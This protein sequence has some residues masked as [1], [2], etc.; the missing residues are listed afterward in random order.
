MRW[1]SVYPAWRF[2]AVILLLWIAARP[3]AAQA[4]AA[5]GCGDPTLTAMGQEKPFRNRV[6]LSLEELLGEHIS[7]TPAETD[8]TSRTTL[9][10]S[11]SP[12]TF[13]TLATAVPL[14]GIRSDAPYR[15]TRYIVGLGDAEFMVRGLVF[16]DRRF[17]P[18]HIIGLL[19]GI[20]APTGPRVNDS[21]GYPADDDLQPGS[22]SWDPE[23]G[24]NYSYFGSLASLFLSVSYRYTTT[25]YRGYRRGS[26]LGG[27]LALQV[28]L[29][30]RTA[31][32]LG[33][34][35]S[36][37]AASELAAQVPAPDTGGFLLSASPGILISL[38]QDWLLRLVMQVPLV[39]RWNGNQQETATGI[40]SLIVDI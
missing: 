31:L 10:A 7:G 35:V 1:R 40:V 34:D 18:H 11:W 8:L 26:V 12:L 33:T 24:A 14:I 23:F 36:Y 20:K 32:V 28:S 27:S 37:A 30:R 21:T 16:R 6:R 3:T 29:L 17:S 39:E 9:S 4:C 13:L 2:F 25:G 22:G 19:L 5:C 15:D 38:R